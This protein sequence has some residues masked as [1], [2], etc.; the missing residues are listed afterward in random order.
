MKYRPPPEL[1]L[2]VR[3][4]LCGLDCLRG[5]EALPPSS[6]TRLL[7]AP[8]ARRSSAQEGRGLWRDAGAAPIITAG[9]VSATLDGHLLLR[10]AATRAGVAAH[11]GSTCHLVWSCLAA[12]ASMQARGLGARAG[13][14]IRGS[15][16]PWWVRRLL[17]GAVASIFCSEAAIA[18]RGS[19][20]GVVA[21]GGGGWPELRGWS[22]FELP[23]RVDGK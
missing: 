5:S 6:R 22:L 10:G 2:S 14:Y 17:Y 19:H 4:H 8:L 9:L 20:D 7:V 18:R 1:L 12:S 15:E 16:Q 13:V 3:L 11:S 23:S 21:V